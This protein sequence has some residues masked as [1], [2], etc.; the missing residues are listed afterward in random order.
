MKKNWEKWYW[1]IVLGFILV[2]LFGVYTSKEQ[3]VYTSEKKIPVNKNEAALWFVGLTLFVAS[4][5]QLFIKF[6]I[7]VVRP[8]IGLNVSEKKNAKPNES[9][10]ANKVNEI[11]CNCSCRKDDKNT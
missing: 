1:L 4:V 10:K 9:N 2:A 8:F 5:F 3:F 11:N 7:G 6:F